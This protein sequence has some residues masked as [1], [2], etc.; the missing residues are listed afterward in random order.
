MIPTATASARPA[1]EAGRVFAC[2]L[3]TAEAEWPH[4]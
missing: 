1:L 3:T 4:G 2:P